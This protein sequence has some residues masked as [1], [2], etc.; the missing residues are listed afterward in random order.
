MIIAMK[1]DLLKNNNGQKTLIKGALDL[2]LV[3]LW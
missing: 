3:R 2:S 1:F